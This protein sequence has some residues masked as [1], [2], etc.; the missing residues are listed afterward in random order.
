MVGMPFNQQEHDEAAIFREGIELF[1]DGEWFEAHE[2]WEDIWH[3]ATGPR[4]LFY[5]GLIQCAVTIEHMRRGNPR[6][7]VTVY[8]SAMTKFRGLDNPYMGIDWMGLTQAI[9]AMVAKVRTLP[10]AMF[11]PRVGRGLAVPVDLASAPKITL[12]HDPFAEHRPQINP[13]GRG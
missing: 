2:S 10:P 12:L 8:E 13:D 6:G 4:K 11:E 9:G 5:Q 3:M 1:N 7:V